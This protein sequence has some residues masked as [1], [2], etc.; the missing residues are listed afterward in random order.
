MFY[1]IVLD[2]VVIEM[3]GFRMKKISIKLI[4]LCCLSFSLLM[5]ANESFDAVFQRESLP[6]SVQRNMIAERDSFVRGVARNSNDQRS[7]QVNRVSS[8]GKRVCENEALNSIIIK[9]DT[10]AC[11]Y[12]CFCPEF[13]EGHL[14]DSINYMFVTLPINATTLKTELE[15]IS[16]YADSSRDIAVRFWDYGKDRMPERY[17]ASFLF[18]KSILNRND[19]NANFIKTYLE[20]NLESKNYAGLNQFD[21]ILQLEQN[22]FIQNNLNQDNALWSVL[23]QMYHALASTSSV[24]LSPSFSRNYAIFLLAIIYPIVLALI[25]LVLNQL[26]WSSRL[27]S[28]LL[29]P[30]LMMLIDQIGRV[31]P[32]HWYQFDILN[33]LSKGWA[34]TKYGMGTAAMA[35]LTWVFYGA[36]NQYRLDV[37]RNLLRERT[38]SSE[39]TNVPQLGDFVMDYVGGDLN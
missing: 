28:A 7:E 25:S 22:Q 17:E 32:P 14:F 16:R 9:T 27:L 23:K 35:F 39:T 12:G 29:L 1:I 34:L 8:S 19:F 30:A 6:L 38:F 10:D 33:M 5:N 11:N 26:S 2:I 37:A 3:I 21:A 24:V 20:S 15:K 18:L 31:S 13:S 36:I 4:G